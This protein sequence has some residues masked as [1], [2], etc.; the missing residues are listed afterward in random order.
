MSAATLTTPVPDAA[1][2]RPGEVDNRSAYV[3]FGLAYV[4]G[5]GATALSKGAD[6]VLSLPGWL[7]MALLG[8]GLVAG[9]VQSTVA[10]IRAQRGAG[11]SE[12]LS[13]KLL[14]AAWISGFAALFLAITGLTAVLEMPELQAILWPVGAGFVVGLLYLAE[15][16]LRRNPL[17][18]ALGT[19]LALISTGS[20]FFG[21]PGLYWVLAVAGGGAYAVAAVLERRRLAAW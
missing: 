15:G 20:L 8:A 5:H 10:A 13:G 6:P 18:Y 4:L 16:A 3:S 12:A 11:E 14:G 17:H 1:A 19:W 9:T 2:P 7:P 21:T